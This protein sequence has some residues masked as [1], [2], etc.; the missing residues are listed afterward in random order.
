MAFTASQTADSFNNH[1][2]AITFSRKNKKSAFTAD[3]YC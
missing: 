1:Q 2:K 3:F